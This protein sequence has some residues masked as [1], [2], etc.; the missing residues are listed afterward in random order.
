MV[1]RSSA[2]VRQH[3][4]NIHGATVR[5]C[6]GATVSAK[7]RRSGAMAR[8]SGAMARQY[9]KNMHGATVRGS[10]VRR[11]VR[12]SDGPVRWSDSRQHPRNYRTSNGLRASSLRTDRRT[13]L[14]PTSVRKLAPT[15]VRGLAPTCVRGLAPTSVRGL[16][17]LA[18]SYLERTV[19]P[20]HG[21]S[22]R[23]TVALSNRFPTGA[24]R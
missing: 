22:H 14:A 12:W 23:R 2:M 4:K 17:P 10:T 7:V 5:G 24:S 3:R 15:C 20:S 1:R 13:V 8:R 9:R 18:P 11:S 16:A 19:A 6:E 21:P